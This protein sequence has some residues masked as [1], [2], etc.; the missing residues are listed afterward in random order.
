[1]PTLN[2]LAKVAVKP[3]PKVISPRTH[4]IAGYITEWEPGR[5][6]AEKA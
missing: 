2:S 6:L 1:M 5:V 4:S 3:I